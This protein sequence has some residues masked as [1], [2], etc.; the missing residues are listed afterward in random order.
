[1]E[2]SVP[3]KVTPSVN[4]NKSSKKEIKQKRKEAKRKFKEEKK[5]VEDNILMD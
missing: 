3:V 1:M 2:S 4:D 5:K